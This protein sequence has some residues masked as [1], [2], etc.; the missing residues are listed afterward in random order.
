M[1]DYGAMKRTWPIGLPRPDQDHHV[2]TARLTKLL[3]NQD[4]N[5]SLFTY[6]SP[7]DHDAYLRPHA[8]YKITDRW[9]VDGGANVLLGQHSYTQFGQLKSNSNVYVGLRYSF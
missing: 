4:L 9:V 2:L 6:W 8:S 1:L 7:S 3:L 5:L